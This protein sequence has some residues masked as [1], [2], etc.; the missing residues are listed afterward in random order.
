MSYELADAVL[1]HAKAKGNDRLV[2]AQIARDT[3]TRTGV[4]NPSVARLVKLT[5]LSERTIQRSIR[6]NV[7]S[8][9][10]VVTGAS[11][12][13]VACTYR[14]VV[15]VPV[16]ES[17]PVT[18]TPLPVAQP[19]HPVG[20][21]RHGVAQPRHG[22][23]RSKKNQGEAAACA[24]AREP[25]E[26]ISEVLPDATPAE[27]AAVWARFSARGGMRDPAAVLATVA[28]RRPRR[29]EALLTEVRAEAKTPAAAAYVAVAATS[30]PIRGVA[31]NADYRAARARLVGVAS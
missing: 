22:D 30:G 17:N 29:L 19:R 25:A 3:N 12:G 16:E 27:V 28:R 10:L 23:T 15:E 21:P 31:P 9:E 18:V 5:G 6:R 26:I 2:L 14:V 20:Q 24:S 8:G 13:R 7:E 11:G 1:S 4:A